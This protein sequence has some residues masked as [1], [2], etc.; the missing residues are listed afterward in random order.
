MYR[1]RHGDVVH[2][3]ESLRSISSIC[4]KESTSISKATGKDSELHIKFRFSV[5]VCI[6]SI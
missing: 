1:I 6:S 4:I 2:N 5:T 3:S